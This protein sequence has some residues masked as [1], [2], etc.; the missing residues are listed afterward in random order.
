L[1]NP[2]K[3][4]SGGF[5]LGTSDFVDWV[6]ETFLSNRSDENEIP[7]LR[8]LKPRIHLDKIIEAVGGEFD[9]GAE[10]ILRKGRKRN[11]ARDVAIYL[12]RELTGETGKRLGEH[13]GNISGAAVTGRCSYL[14]RQIEKNRKLRVHVNRLRDKIINN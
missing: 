9:C 3:D 1:E 2:V 14:S 10:S 5:I 11:M 8:K 13:F 12:A 6:K 7:Q 4:L